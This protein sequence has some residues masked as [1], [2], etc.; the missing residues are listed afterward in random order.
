MTDEQ[1]VNDL[2]MYARNA[3]EWM[4]ETADRLTALLGENEQLRSDLRYTIAWM[5]KQ[6]LAE[7][8]AD[9]DGK[10]IYRIATGDTWA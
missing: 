6:L 5:D 4:D 3:Y 2:R 9:P 8:R 7:F 10:R 1:L